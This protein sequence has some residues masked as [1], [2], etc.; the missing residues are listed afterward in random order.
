MSKTMT[1]G[2]DLAKNVFHMVCCN[3]HGKVVRKKMLMRS[4]L[5][6]YLANLAD[7]LVG[8]EAC[9]SAYHWARE[10]GALGHRVK[11]DS[12]TVRQ[13]VRVW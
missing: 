2:L 5:I 10:L 1:I 3:E 7:C 13:C 9:S 8:M 11:L 12:A 4:Q 6:E